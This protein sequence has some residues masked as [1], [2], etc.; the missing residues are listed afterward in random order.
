M[1]ERPS[2]NQPYKWEYVHKHFPPE[3]VASYRKQLVD[4]RTSGQYTDKELMKRYGMS[5]QTFYNTINRYTHA[6]EERDY[7]DK[8]KAPKNPARKIKPEDKKMIQQMV[9]ND[10]EHLGN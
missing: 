5:K 3:E 7:M 4:E 8:S 1:T 10:R 9:K 6:K 2:N